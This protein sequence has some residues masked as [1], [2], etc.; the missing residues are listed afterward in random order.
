MIAI[1]IIA[2][3]GLFL[4][5]FGVFACAIALEKAQA[6]LHDV[7]GGLTGLRIELGDIRAALEDVA[8]LLDDEDGPP[9]A[10]AAAFTVRGEDG[11]RG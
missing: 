6:Y 4:A 3:G 9:P 11:A 7:A 10:K 8:E 5:V 2:V 1:Q